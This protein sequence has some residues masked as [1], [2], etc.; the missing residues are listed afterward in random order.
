MNQPFQLYTEPNF[1]QIH[2]DEEKR[3]LKKDATYIGVLSIALTV[4]ME[5]TFTILVLALIYGGVFSPDQLS[6]PYLGLNNTHYMLLYICVYVFALLVPAVL[7][8][9]FF[10]KRFCPFSPAK[11]VKFEVA[12]F[13]I[14]GAMGTCML[15]NIINTYFSAFFTEV[16]L[17]VPEAPQTMVNTPI[18]LLLNI[19]TM[20][21]LPA[22]LEEMVYRGYILRTL[23]PYGNLFAIVVSSALF[24]LMHGN[25]RQIP[26]AFIV[27]LVLGYLYVVTDN[28]WMPIAVHFGNNCFSVLLEYAGFYLPEERIGVFYTLAI[29]GLLF[30][31]IIAAIVLFIRSKKSLAV[32]KS[33]NYLT[34]GQK[35]ATLLTNPLFLISILLYAFLLILES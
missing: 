28:V 34:V 14:I 31:G 7:V 11:P 17:D 6:E 33:K 29:Y 22:L 15:S 12:T 30:L 5:F 10:K 32:P 27:G 3:N 16:G 4:F 21:V 19:F 13:A 24:S 20:A 35:T 18:S 26:F 2:T 23:R 9:F 8:S 1:Q 25:L